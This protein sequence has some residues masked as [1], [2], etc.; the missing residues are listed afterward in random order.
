MTVTTEDIRPGAYLSDIIDAYA[1]SREA[2]ERADEVAKQKRETMEKVEAQL[3]AEMERQNLRSVKHDR[4]TFYLNDQAWARVADEVAARQW[5][6]HEH[7]EL[8]TLNR[9]RL[10]VL[11]REALKEGQPLPPGV[12]FTASQKVGWRDRRSG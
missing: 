3:F 2:Y 7:P 1:L 10:S 11:V 6:Q 4:G 12:D 5:A 9:S 8:I